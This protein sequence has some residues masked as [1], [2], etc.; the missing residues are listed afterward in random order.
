[1][2]KLN[3]FQKI[4]VGVIIFFLVIGILLKT[5]SGSLTKNLG[6]DAISMLKYS[7]IDNPV[8]TVS[9]WLDDLATLWKVQEENDILQYELS[10]SPSYKAKYEDEKRKNTELEEA[11]A[12]KKKNTQFVD[13]WANVIGRDSTN[14]NNEITIDV[15]KKDGIKEGM[16]VESVKGMIGKVESVSSYTSI[17]KL[18]TCEDK[19]TAASIKVNVNEKKSVH[20]ALQGFDIKKGMYVVYLY[21][22]SDKVKKGMPVI[23]SGMGKGY[24]SGLLIGTIDSVQSLSNQSGQ[25]TFVKP[26]DDFNEFSIVRVVKENLEDEKK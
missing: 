15:G 14:W 16:A 25:T 7:F 8:K 2:S 11:L 6:Y 3:R 17:V 20:G 1:M 9:G 10:K 19:S 18:L 24:P 4:V 21:E 5:M 23:T 26:V 13:V 22:D 12:L